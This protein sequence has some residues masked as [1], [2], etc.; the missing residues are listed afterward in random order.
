MRNLLLILLSAV[1]LIGATRAN[2][3]VLNHI[4]FLP[5]SA[6]PVFGNDQRLAELEIDSSLAIQ[7]DHPAFLA[8]LARRLGYSSK[9]ES[10]VPRIEELKKQISQ[11][12]ELQRLLIMTKKTS[13]ELNHARALGKTDLKALNGQFLAANKALSDAG[14]PLLTGLRQKYKVSDPALYQKLSM[15]ILANDYQPIGN[16]LEEEAVRLGALLADRITVQGKVEILITATLI[17]SDGSSRPVHLDGYD[18]YDVGG[19]VPFNRFQVTTDERTAKEVAAAESMADLV[20]KAQSGA[21]REEAE[22]ALKELNSTVKDLRQTLETD[23][24][25]ANIDQLVASLTT[26]GESNLSPLITGALEVRQLLR[27]VADSPALPETTDANR[28]LA[29]ADNIQEIVNHLDA[30][31]SVAPSQIE[32]LLADVDNELKKRPG[33]VREDLMLALKH[34]LEKLKKSTPAVEAIRADA[35]SVLA[36][37]GIL[38]GV[39]AAIDQSL[40]KPRTL[41]TNSNLDTRLDLQTIPGER[42]SGDRL[43][44]QVTVSR[45]QTVI[46]SGRKS[47]RLEAYGPFVETRGALLFVNSRDNLPGGQDFEPAPGLSFNLHYGWEN[48]PF[49]NHIIRPGVGISLAMLDFDDQKSLEIGIGGNITLINDIFWLGY[50]YNLQAK[51]D[52]FYVGINP[53]VV[54]RLF[55]QSTGIGKGWQ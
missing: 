46:D 13:L 28:L 51:V 22:K 4:N 45:N 26:A 17:S 1:V 55:S 47:F 15:A 10:L 9:E 21:L 16:V 25:S 24:L 39:E 52:Y 20:K 5:S 23:V 19:P 44:I 11:V 40:Q 2:A 7:W 31:A 43:N 42:H 18:S 29:L 54:G 50:G 37:L 34:S 33:L 38:N 8:D 30:L 35:K 27:R 36:S 14:V 53:L 32:K 41:L 3:E 48:S 12:V 6:P 49:W